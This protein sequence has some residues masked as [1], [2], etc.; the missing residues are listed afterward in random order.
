MQKV[1]A[2]SIYFSRYPIRMKGFIGYV[3]RE[4]LSI[5]LQI[6]ILG[7]LVLIPFLRYSNSPLYPESDRAVSISIWVTGLLLLSILTF[8]PNAIR[9]RP[10]K[11]PAVLKK[12]SNPLVRHV[13]YPLIWM[14][15]WI[16]IVTL[17][18]G[19]SKEALVGS[20][21]R[22]D[23]LWLFLS[24]I[25]GTVCIAIFSHAFGINLL[26]KRLSQGWFV[27]SLVIVGI[28]LASQLGVGTIRSQLATNMGNNL[29]VAGVILFGALW[30]GLVL[31]NVRGLLAVAVL[32]TVLFV[33]FKMDIV[34]TLLIG[35][36]IF[37]LSWVIVH[38]KKYTVFCRSKLM[39]R[40]G[41]SVA[42]LVIVVF[43]GW[44][45]SNHAEDLEANLTSHEGRVTIYS[46]FFTAYQQKPILG[47]GW[48]GMEE[49]FLSQFSSSEK[50]HI[51]VADKT[52]SVWLDWLIMTGFPG[53]I[54]YTLLVAGVLVELWRRGKWTTRS[55]E[56]SIIWF[57]LA[58]LATI[59][60]LLLA[61]VN[62]VSV[63]VELGWWLIV[64]TVLVKDRETKQR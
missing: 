52:H 1:P 7:G 10:L 18:N 12:S 6:W 44:W 4:Y 57:K 24:Y 14:L 50:S 40:I 53:L 32:S 38:H 45:I 58:L 47:W 49:A 23:G 60:Y 61:T 39:S 59:V 62:V 8:L 41:V 35:I 13:A 55:D 63:Y 56:F 31:K 34:L 27:A 33:L 20:A 46:T 5:V 16:S 26:S 28:W 17:T 42:V 37:P 36:C 48:S 3:N 54:L 43:S 19:V 15:I 30:S 22:G 9:F 64:G 25:V 11:S 51:V 2:D 29:Y 21:L